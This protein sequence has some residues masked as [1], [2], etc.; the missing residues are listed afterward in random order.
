MAD[1]LPYLLLL[2]IPLLLVLAA[3][4]G[5]FFMGRNSQHTAQASLKRL[6]GDLRRFQS[7]RKQLEQAAEAYSV[8]DPEPYRSRVTGLRQKLAILQRRSDGLEQRHVDLH[9]L[10]ADLNR[11]RWQTVLS[12][13]F[14]W[15]RLSQQAASLEAELAQA[16]VLL[17]QAVQ[18]EGSIRSLSWEVA[19]QAR[20]TIQHQQ[21]L[22]LV[23]RELRE[24]NLYG[25]TFESA[26]E[27]E[28]QAL[29]ALALIPPLYLDADEAG[30]LEGAS[31]EYTALVY[32]LVRLNRPKLEELLI[33]SR[34]W[35]TRY[36]TTR[37]TLEGMR[38]ALDGLGVTLTGLPAGID[39]SQELAK[40]QQLEV[41]AQSLQATL[42]RLEVESME[43]VSQEAGKVT[44]AAQEADQSLRQARGEWSTLEALLSELA[45]GFSDLSLQL[46][47]LGAKSSYPV[48]W[49]VSLELLA[50]LNRKANSLSRKRKPRNPQALNADLETARQISLSQQE[51]SRRS[52]DLGQDHT[53]LLML[54]ESPQLK[55][56]PEW[57]EKARQITSKA[58]WY[59]SENWRRTDGIESLSN[60]VQALSDEASRLISVDPAEP[61]SELDLPERLDETRQLAQE[62]SLVQK[63]LEDVQRRLQELQQSEEQAQEQLDVLAKLLTQIQLV[64]SSNQFL[65]GIA[66][67]ETE[68]LL[69]S[70]QTLQRELADPQNGSVEKKVRQA[71]DL[72][73][74]AEGFANRWLE[75]IAKEIQEQTREM[76]SDLAKLDAIAQLEDSSVAEAHRLLASAQPSLSG[77]ARARLSL[78]D[79]V[80]ELKKRSDF[81]H[82]CNAVQKALE[83]VHQLVETYEETSYQRQKT[84]ELISQSSSWGGQKRSWPPTS[85]TLEAETSELEKIEGQFQALKEQ[86]GKA[87]GLVAQFSNLSTRYQTL[88]ERLKQGV[89]RAAQEQSQVED[90]EASISDLT[91]PWQNM[92]AE[93]R[94]NPDASLEIHQLLDST[95]LELKRIRYQYLRS[96]MDYNQVLIALKT[97]QRKVRFYQVALDDEHAVDSSGRVTRRRQS[98]RE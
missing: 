61:I 56:L 1:Y 80:L 97:L 38:Q 3:L 74:R 31:V 98:E 8:D 42:S 70:V 36:E 86:G 4:A 18:L 59:A 77:M 79:T 17:G 76:S 82:E 84:R 66:G 10:A 62:Y 39:G 78:E 60:V 52:L 32:E 29:A 5:M 6:R 88:A 85:T 43:L 34:S 63:R 46:A 55:Q 13:P 15:R 20:D 49:E 40:S 16:N 11:R 95:E 83:N 75:G 35:K 14:D 64:V 81:W 54:L 87:I 21:D 45:N 58:N 25:D 93:Y 24:F 33:Q 37:S 68:R 91:S 47:T 67:Q 12:A 73:N 30:L 48:K 28:R 65:S 41:I 89:G 23:M 7:D 57:L 27:Q 2:I 72:A 9:Q 19:R 92:L 50:G 26:I 53:D 96:G 44:L 90:L 94:D 69:T 71:G 51:L 22:N